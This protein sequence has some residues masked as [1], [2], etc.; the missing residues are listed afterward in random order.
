MPSRPELAA[1]FDQ[2]A[3]ELPVLLLET[4]EHGQHLGLD[5]LAG[6]LCHEAMLVGEPLRS[7]DVG[8]SRVLE[9]PGATPKMGSG[10][11]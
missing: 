8:G 10:V 4:I 11:I 2:R 9:Q 7:E 3:R 6:R 1:A 5:E